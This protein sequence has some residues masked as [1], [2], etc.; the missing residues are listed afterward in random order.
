[1][2]V[3]ADSTERPEAGPIHEGSV[4]VTLVVIGVLIGV[5]CVICVICVIFVARHQNRQQS[6]YLLCINSLS[7]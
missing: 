5:I 1:M 2:V 6:A 7:E 3:T 4:N